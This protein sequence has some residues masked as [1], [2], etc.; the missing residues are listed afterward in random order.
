MTG[1]RILVKFMSR[2][3]RRIEIFRTDSF[4]VGIHCG[5]AGEA[6]STAM[7]PLVLFQNEVT[8]P[9]ADKQ[10]YRVV[11]WSLVVAVVAARRMN[12]T[13]FM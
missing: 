8:L 1:A 7:H 9:P 5:L 13:I 3:G 10:T 12:V 4:Y 6:P 11:F 2:V